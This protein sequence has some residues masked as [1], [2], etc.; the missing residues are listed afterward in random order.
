LIKWLAGLS[1]LATF[2]FYV[3]YTQ[4]DQQAS[5]DQANG[6]DVNGF[7]PQTAEASGLGSGLQAGQ[8]SR[9]DQQASS[10]RVA[11]R[12]QRIQDFELQQ[13]ENNHFSANTR[14]QEQVDAVNSSDSLLLTGDQPEVTASPVPA[15]QKPTTTKPKVS[16]P[17]PTTKHTSTTQAKPRAKATP[18][19]NSDSGTTE[20]TWDQLNALLNDPNNNTQVQSDTGNTAQQ[21]QAQAQDPL[22]LSD[23][24][25]QQQ[26][27]QDQLQQQQDQ[28][29]VQQQVQPRR[30]WRTSRS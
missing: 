28:Q 18:D 30:R 4:P 9:T 10:N 1:A 19:A 20:L 2:G 6:P 11:H 15:S 14:D 7:D 16:K 23:N 29:Q 24:S 13:Q 17:H 21:D 27:P 3:H 25:V 22:P 8:T 5:P 12:A 26:Q